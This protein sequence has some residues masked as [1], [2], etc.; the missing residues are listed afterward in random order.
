MYSACKN[1][2]AFGTNYDTIDGGSS[3][4]LKN[5]ECNNCD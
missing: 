5:T 1:N 3:I 2:R 4:Y